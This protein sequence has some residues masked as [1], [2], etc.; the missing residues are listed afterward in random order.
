[1]TDA[2]ITRIPFADVPQ[3]SKTDAD[4]ATHPDKF[5]DFIAGLPELA[6]FEQVIRA[7][8]RQKIPRVVLADVIHQ[9]YDI[10]GETHGSIDLLREDDQ[11][12]VV[13]AHQ[14]AL[15]TGPL[16]FIYKICSTINLASQLRRHY[17]AYGFHPLFVLGGEDHDFEEINHLH[18]FGKDFT[19]ETE[20][21]GP[22][23]RLSIDSLSSTLAMIKEVLGK[24]PHSAELCEMIDQCFE[25]T[26]SYG[27]A[28]HKFVIRLFRDTPLL[29]VQLDDPAL[30]AEFAGVMEDELF[31][32]TSQTHIAQSQR[33]IEAIGYKP[34]AY[35]RDIN[36]FYLRDDL[37]GRLARNESGFE[38]VDSSYHFTEEE[39]RNEL[40][41]Q[42]QRFSPNVN[43][44]PLYQESILPNLAYVGGG[45][46]LAY[47]LERK[48]QFEHYQVP[49]P[50]L[51][52]RGSALHI[53]AGS[54]KQL[55]KLDIPLKAL[56]E[57]PEKYIARWVR[58]HSSHEIE[59]GEEYG[60]V[61]AALSAIQEKA[62]QIDPT[63]ARKVEAFKVK[64]LKDIDHLGKRLVREEKALNENA[65]NKIRKLFDKLF[66]Q[67]GLQ[68][69]HDNFMQFYVRHGKA[70]LEYLVAHLD[71]LERSFYVI[72]EK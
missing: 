30:K 62:A 49:F 27:Q 25:G 34:Q 68:E 51:I 35:I 48:R 18:L 7:K 46:E 29:V 60:A 69:R 53:D 28:M 2:T 9:Q 10:L 16:Y 17:P 54:A 45:G 70:Y 63:V 64:T 65:V 15:L 32:E 47:W 19:W 55:S 59:I 24:S 41:E 57:E 71:P 38:V 22:V 50:L 20:S 39:M 72:S 21:H 36:L 61:D 43:L 5:S 33:A 14:P 56:F 37:R 12:T 6:A 40:R 8:Q 13:T 23:G 4:Y 67:M 1:M 52:R 31:N 58:Q 66:P 44:R 42:P 26:R 11:F 3:L